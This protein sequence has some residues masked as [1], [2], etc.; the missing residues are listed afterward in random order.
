MRWNHVVAT[1]I[2]TVGTQVL[3]VGFFF[4]EIVFF[5][6][7]PDTYLHLILWHSIAIREVVNFP[8]Y[9]GVG[10]GLA[11]STVRYFLSEFTQGQFRQTV[12]INPL[13]FFIKN[14]EEALGATFKPVSYKSGQESVI[15]TIAGVVDFNLEG[16][17]NVVPQV[18]TG[19]L[20]LL[21][22]ASSVPWFEMPE[23]TT[24]K[25]AGVD[26][27]VESYAGLAA[28]AGVPED[29]LKFLEDAFAAAINDPEVQETMRSLGMEP[30]YFSSD[31]YRA[32]LQDG[33]ERMA[34]DLVKIGLKK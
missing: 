20:R 23:V 8:L 19:N 12:A 32:L 16:P 25:G 2:E 1:T 29:R 34:S 33:H 28:P 11:A 3:P 30:T 15:A 17:T 27:F 31:A 7:E 6:V 18:K 22:S 14:L 9:L 24:L 5:I 4:N 13:A 10:R 26:L 21:A